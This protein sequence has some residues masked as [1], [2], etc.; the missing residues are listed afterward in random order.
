MVPIDQLTPQ[1]LPDELEEMQW[2]LKTIDWLR[3]KKTHR[4]KIDVLK[5]YLE[6]EFS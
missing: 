6:K 3:D 4:S 5:T 1:L 2:I